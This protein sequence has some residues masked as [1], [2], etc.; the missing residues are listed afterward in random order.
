MAVKTREEIMNSINERFGEQTDDETIAFIEDVS[1]TLTDLT[2]KAQ[3]DGT[4]WKKK[5]EDNDKEWRQKYKDRFFSKV[6]DNEPDVD[7]EPKKPTRFE[8]LFKI[9]ED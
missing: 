9:K 2:E 7:P 8:D 3:G 6:D 4:D 1:D 5:Y